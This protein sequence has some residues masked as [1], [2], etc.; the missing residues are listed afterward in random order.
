MRP[1]VTRTDIPELPLLSRGKVRDMYD[2]GDNVLI[3]VT[4]RLSAF[5]HI[6]PNGI[7]DKGRVLN[8]LTAFW[9]ERTQDIVPNHL[10]GIDVAD[11]PDVLRGHADMLEGRFTIARKAEMLPVECI[12]RGYLSGSGWEE[13]RRT[14]AVSGQSLPSGLVESDRLPEPLFTPSTKAESGH[15][16]NITF[17]QAAALVGDEL[18][19]QVRDVSIALYRHAVDYASSRGIL[20]ADTKFEFGL[21]DGRLTLCDEVLTPDSSRFWPANAYAPGRSQPSFDKQ[22]VRDWLLGIHWNKEPPVPVLPDEV[23]V[24]TSAKYRE[25]YER[26]TGVTL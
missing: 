4:D 21:L 20:I 22:Y 7:P 11:L 14:G 19:A 23:V 1:V 17:A 2:L 6:L 13:Y 3:V 16:E 15:D 8:L 26:L 24:G 9:M 12:V 10:V 18:A 5:D 25:A